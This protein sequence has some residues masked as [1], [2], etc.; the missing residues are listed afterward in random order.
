MVALND[1]KGSDGKSSRAWIRTGP[2]S[3]ARVISRPCLILHPFDANG[4]TMILVLG[5]KQMGK[6]REILL[7]CGSGGGRHE[8]VRSLTPPASL[9]IVFFFVVIFV[10]R[11]LAAY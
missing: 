8:T 7:Y 11:M 2:F 10:M 9:I 3:N 4:V 5:L 1:W 6:A